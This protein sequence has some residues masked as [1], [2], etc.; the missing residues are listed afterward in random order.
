PVAAPM[1]ANS[2]FDVSRDGR[3]I[4]YVGMERPRSPKLFLRRLDQFEATAI[5]GTEGAQW[6]PFFSPDGQFVGF[7]ADGKLKKISVT[8]GAAPVVI[9]EVEAWPTRVM[10]STPGTIFFRGG[11]GQGIERVSAEGG[12]PRAVTTVDTKGH[13]SDHHDPELL[14]DGQTLLFSIH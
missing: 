3:Q 5:P 14:P 13:E 6:Q 7:W 10:W 8:T 12:Q 1:Q 4:V 2:S 9:C 11:I